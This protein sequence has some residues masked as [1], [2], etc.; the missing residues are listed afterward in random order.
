MT[1]WKQNEK[2]STVSSLDLF[3]FIYFCGDRPRCVLQLEEESH[4]S[5]MG[6]H[7]SQ[8]KTNSDRYRACGGSA[9]VAA[10]DSVQSQQ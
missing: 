9:E 1:E 6:E 7:N 5:K 8:R 2:L 10:A 3:L 4:I